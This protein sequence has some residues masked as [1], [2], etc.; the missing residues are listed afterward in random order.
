MQLNRW[1]EK[2][3]SRRVAVRYSMEAP[4]GCICKLQKEPDH[5]KN[6]KEETRRKALQAESRR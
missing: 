5:E 6:S 3:G 1:N 4:Q 2:A